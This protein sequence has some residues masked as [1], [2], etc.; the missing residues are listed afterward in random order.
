MSSVL[1]INKPVPGADQYYPLNDPPIGTALPVVTYPQN[2]KIPILFQPLTLRGVT[3]KN[4]IFVSPMCQYSSDN[5]HATDWHLVHLG[6]FATRGVGAICVEASAVLP[7]A[8]I[9]PEDSVTFQG[10]WDDSHIPGLKRI[11]D[12]CHAQG[13]RIGIQL[14]HAGRKASTYP[15]F[16]HLNAAKTRRATKWFA[17]KEENGWPNDVFA[18]SEVPFADDHPK[19]KAMLTEDLI[20]VE[21]AF[22][23]AVERA[24]KAGFDFI[25]L[26]GAHGYLLHEFVSPLSN[27]RTDTYGGSLENRLRYPLQLIERVRKAWDKPLF[28]RIS[29]TE[30]GEGS[31]KGQNGEWRYWG[32][33]QSKIYV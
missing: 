1:F 10:I 7:E 19:P 3:F 22:L 18:P 5:G 16:V 31:E 4:R 26:H 28:V 13:T 2:A 32:L 23:A 12:F 11:V 33:E 20:R 29:A 27:I 8:R 30:W 6:G 15:P 17:D 21:E 24:K 25:E 14:S 9:S